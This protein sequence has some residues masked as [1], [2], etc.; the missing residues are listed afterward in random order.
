MITYTGSKSKVT[1]DGIESIQN[2]VRREDGR[3]IDLRLDLRNHSPTGFE[4]GYGGSGPAQLALAI[5]ADYAEDDELA[6]EHYQQFKWDVISKFEKD[7]WTLT[8]DEINNALEN[9]KAKKSLD[10]AV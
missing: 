2:L 6:C 1:I 9:I 5:L 4:W 8:D 7:M 10:M 3:F